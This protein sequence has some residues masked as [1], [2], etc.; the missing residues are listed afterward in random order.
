LKKPTELLYKPLLTQCCIFTSLL[1]MSTAAFSQEAEKE[2]AKGQ[3]ELETITITSRKIEENLQAAPLSVQAF[4]T[5]GLESR[6]VT[7][8]SQIGEFTP[9]MKFDR[10]AA[11][12]GSNSTAVV[13][14]R[15]IGQESGLPT[16]DQGVGMYVDGVYMARS[17]GG[18][19]DLVDVERVEVVRGP[20]GTL[21]GRNTIGGAVSMVSKKPSEDFFIDTSLS[22]GTDKLRE[23]KLTV[24]GGL[25]DTLSAMFSVLKKDRDGYVIRPDGTDFGNED[26]TAGRLALRYTPSEDLSF[27]LIIDATESESNGAP[28]ELVDVDR[29]AGFPTFHNAFVAPAT[30]GCFNPATGSTSSAD[31]ACYN[32]HSVSGLDKDN[33]NLAALD[34]LDAFG[35]ALTAEYEI[36][37]NLRFKSITSYRDSESDFAIDQDH[38]PLTI[39]HVLSNST[40]DQLTQ[41]FQLLGDEESFKYI[42]GAF[43]FEEESRYIE[44]IDF[45]PVSFTSGGDNDNDSKALFGQLTYNINDALKVT[46]G[47]RYTKEVKRFTPDSVLVSPLPT[48]NGLAPAGTRVLP[49]TTE[50]ITLSETTPMVNLSYNW[51]EGLMTYLTYSEG[52]KSGG[53][54]QRVFPPQPDIPSFLP[55]YADVVELGFKWQADNNRVRVNG[56]LFQTDYT[57]LQIISQSQSVAPI[58][59]NAGAAEIEGIELDL[60]FVPAEDWLIEASLGYLDAQYTE[61]DAGTGITLAHKLVKTPELSAVAAVAHTT[62]FN[63]SSLMAR[64]DYSYSDEFYNNAINSSFLKQDSYGLVNLTFNYINYS[65]DRNTWEVLIYA[66]NLTDE[67]Y[68]S[69]GYSEQNG[70]TNNLGSSEVVRDRGRQYG[71]KF[72][73]NYE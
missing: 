53:F 8:V 4:S 56:A 55:E 28:F 20:Q 5:K 54:T 41:E 13:Y 65:D 17:V 48:P 66:K 24:N 60:Q 40:Q 69:A 43:Y 7:D 12:G 21:F 32:E 10:A 25:T 31:P 62:Y 50:E 70:P 73:Y 59:Q 30:A 29:T 26:L 15:G 51:N 72:K 11:I 19:F 71:I 58:V 3:S 22:L 63:D 44:N 18:V 16:I 9:N 6:G 23:V 34:V 57:D 45:A 39:A 2:E 27:D 52:F 36:N 33:G 64:I 14:I 38:S 68:I 35:I 37:D 61:L 42:I 49:N 1:T 47:A 46:V 67:R